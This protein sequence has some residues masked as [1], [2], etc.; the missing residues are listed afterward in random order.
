MK[1]IL[2]AA[3]PILFAGIL[4]AQT[5]LSYWTFD[6]DVAGAS[7]NNGNG[8]MTNTGTKGGTWNHGKTVGMETDGLGNLVI[9]NVA[10]KYRKFPDGGYPAGEF[11][12]GKYRLVIDFTAWKMDATNS[13][14]L[15]FEV[16]DIAG[17]RIVGL[18]LY[19][20]K[21]LDAKVRF[22]AACASG[23]QG[24]GVD[25]ASYIGSLVN[26]NAPTL[27]IEFDFDYDTVSYL[28]NGAVLK[29]ITDFNANSLHQLKIFTDAKWSLSAQASINEM[30]LI[31]LR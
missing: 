5:Q 22:S 23:W 13:G 25:Y 2:T 1:Y 21:G 24:K 16:T 10:S 30:G 29:T 31:K 9:S 6:T 7:F 26:A 27:A 20:E 4:T 18:N 17:N 28:V 3:L 15:A 11:T 14:S 8:G 12:S 19:A